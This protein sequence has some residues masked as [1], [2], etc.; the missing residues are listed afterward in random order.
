MARLS[1]SRFMTGRQCH[2]QLWWTVHEPDAPELKSD[3]GQ[4]VVFD[5]GSHVGEVARTYIPDGVL[6]DLPHYEVEQRI[7]ATQ[8]AIEGGAKVIYE[9]A[10]EADGV[11]VAVDILH[12][13]RG[14]WTLSE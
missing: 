12:R 6:I 9:A 13:R 14:G 10:F 3:P 7:A 4:A 5:R 11:F 8:K 2:R 1:K